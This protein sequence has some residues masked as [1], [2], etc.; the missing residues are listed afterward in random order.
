MAAIG[1]AEMID[2]NWLKEGAV[3]I[4]VG[5][6]RIPVTKEDGSEGSKIVGDVDFESASA[7]SFYD[8]SSTWRCWSNDNCMFVKKYCHFR[9]S[10]C[11]S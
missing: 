3:V 6:N 9:L 10:S 5:I 7:K 2:A 11:R 8:Y 1:R 4:D